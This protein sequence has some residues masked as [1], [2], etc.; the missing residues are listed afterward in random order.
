M[1]GN[2]QY[3]ASPV[4]QLK[5]N[6]GLLKYLLLGTITLG[7]YP[8]VVMSALSD[9]INTIAGRYDGKKTMHYCLLFFLIGPIT[10]EIAT[11]VWYHRVSNRIGDELR[12]R[13]IAS[14]FGASSFWLWN[15][16]GSLIVVGPFIYLYQLLS[17]MNQL[18][19]DYNR[20]G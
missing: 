11:L 6:R 4:R 10:G 13:G 19:A 20:V 8:L 15:V 2:N 5:T 16:L 18:A 14:K 1:D 17:S 9:D 3:T 7:I 12:R